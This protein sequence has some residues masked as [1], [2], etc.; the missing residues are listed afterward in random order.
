MLTTSLMLYLLRC[1]VLLC[2][3]T[4]RASNDHAKV[5]GIAIAYIVFMQARVVPSLIG[6]LIA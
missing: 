6:I 1:I 5:I 3:I 4:G 2:E